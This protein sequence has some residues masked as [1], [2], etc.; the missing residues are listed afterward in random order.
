MNGELDRFDAPIWKFSELVFFYLSFRIQ[1]GIFD[2]AA[3]PRAD[4]EFGP[5]YLEDDFFGGFVG[6][7]EVGASAVAAVALHDPVRLFIAQKRYFKQVTVGL[8]SF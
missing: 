6:D 8:K 2:V 7:R 1:N 5:F 4:A 3:V